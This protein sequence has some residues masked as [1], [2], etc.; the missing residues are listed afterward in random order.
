MCRIDDG[1]VCVSKE[2]KHKKKECS[3]KLWLRNQFHLIKI[4]DLVI[5]A[6]IAFLGVAVNFCC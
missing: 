1:V 5:D 4:Y 6:I 2:R 3:I